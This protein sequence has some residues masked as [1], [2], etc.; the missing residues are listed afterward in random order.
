MK[1][2]IKA[3]NLTKIKILRDRAIEYYDQ[4]NMD[5]LEKTIKAIR[6][7]ENKGDDE[8]MLASSQAFCDLMNH[9]TRSNGFKNSDEAWAHYRKEK[10]SE[11]VASEALKN[12]P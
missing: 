7:F 10:T 1:N 3:R 2:H 4:N 8:L 6:S 12:N 5:A 9:D 11:V